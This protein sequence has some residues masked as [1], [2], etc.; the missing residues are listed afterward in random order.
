MLHTLMGSSKSGKEG[1]PN[2]GRIA[3]IV[4][5][6]AMDGMNIAR[7]RA[8]K[9]YLVNLKKKIKFGLSTKLT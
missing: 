1:A 3:T 2:A 8:I 7:H 9:S 5:I 6:M 4:R